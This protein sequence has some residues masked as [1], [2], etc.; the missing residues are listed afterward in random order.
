M[1][2]E[3]DQRWQSMQEMRAALLLLKQ[4]ADS[5]MLRTQMGGPAVPPPSKKKKAGMLP[6]L[7]AAATVVVLA[8]GGTGGWLWMK[9][10]KAQ[11]A[12]PPV[13]AQPIPTP[14]EP[15]LPAFDPT[16]VPPPDPAATPPVD[17]GLTNKD[18]LDMVAAKLPA[19]TIINHIR[20]SPKT[21]FDL[22]TA[23]II[24]LSQGGVP[25]NIIAVMRSP[26]P[27]ASA[28]AKS[29]PK[30]TPG[31]LPPANKSAAPQPVPT[32]LEAVPAPAA[33]AP[34]VPPPPVVDSP[35]VS[36]AAAAPT[37]IQTVSIL[38][39]MPFSLTLN[40]DVPAK[41]TAGQLLHFTVTKD[42]KVGDVVIIA[43]GT[44]VN[45]AVVDPGDGKKLLIV[46][47][48]ATFKLTNVESTGGSRLAIRAT[49]SKKDEKAERPIEQAGS[50]NKDVLAPAG[51]EYLG[52]IEN[53]QTVTIK[54]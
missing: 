21:G 43:K 19:S 35:P 22:T 14:A 16:A 3:P 44:P 31:N 29:T 15:P 23:G 10:R 30:S 36:A 11:Q 53:D 41:L 39:G 33:A 28:A 12:P 1:R 40:Q 6:V 27:D 46:K 47:N 26:K 49:Q 7:I 37:R 32:P 5:G 20:S 50:K 42:V 24:Q 48:K 45:G 9:H 25:D 17:A 4:K 38:G 18:V 51:T 13:A 54:H 34:V 52:Y 8:A 2:K